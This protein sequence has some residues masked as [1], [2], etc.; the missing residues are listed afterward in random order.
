MKQVEK[1]HWRIKW[2]GRWTSTRIAF[3]EDQ[4]RREHPEAT[5]IDNT[6]IVVELPESEAEIQ[7]RMRPARR[8]VSG[9]IVIP[10]PMRATPGGKPFTSPEWLYE[11]KFDGYRCLARAGGA[12]VQL[13]TKN[14]TDCTAWYPEV[15]LALDKLPGGPH[16]LDGEACVL[17]D[18][19]RSNF[20]RLHA[21]AAHRSWYPGC[22]PV[23]FCV[24]DLLFHEGRSIMGL[25]L[26]ERK[27]RLVRLLAGVAGVLV[28]GDMPAE[29]DL[30][31]Q[32]VEPLLLEG[33]V[34]KRRASIYTPGVRSPDWLKIKRA[35]AVPPQRFRR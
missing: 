28:V 34:A 21:R 30:F 1:W 29:A 13:R 25:P 8:G 9:A 16:V 24:F 5:R 7:A 11:I 22:D 26:M 14:G 4:I 31:G 2:G 23:T 18:L 17:D 6:R 12:S 35:G 3:T 19:G 33:F 20:S 15:S 27:A 10:E 32:A